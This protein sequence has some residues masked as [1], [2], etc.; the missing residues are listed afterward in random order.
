M[1]HV[2]SIVTAMVHGL[3]SK[4]NLNCTIYYMNENVSKDGVVFV[5]LVLL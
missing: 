5:V 4:Y 2:K 1:A 3:T